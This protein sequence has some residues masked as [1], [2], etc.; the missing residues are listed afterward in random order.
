MDDSPITDA[1]KPFCF[2]SDILASEQIDSVQDKILDTTIS[3][4]LREILAI[5]TNLQE[6][7]AVLKKTRPEDVLEAVEN[8]DKNREDNGNVSQPEKSTLTCNSLD[9]VARVTDRYAGVV[10]VYRNGFTG[11]FGELLTKPI[12]KQDERTL[13][14][15]A[16]KGSEM[17]QHVTV[18][19]TP[20]EATH[21]LSASRDGEIRYCS[22]SDL[23]FS[24]METK[25]HLACVSMDNVYAFYQKGEMGQN[26]PF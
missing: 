22:A 10:S 16:E 17:T 7:F 21:D 1:P 19:E 5:S 15:V 13:H 11:K 12:E 4:P 25:V 18:A 20:Q 23:Q 26:L 3:L 24:R 2:A 9:D 6:K 8:E 14:N